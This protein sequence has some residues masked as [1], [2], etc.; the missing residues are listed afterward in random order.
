MDFKQ[1]AMRELAL[2]AGVG[3]GI[4][5]GRL[6][7]WRTVCAVEQSRYRQAVL[8]A[9]QNDGS[10]APFPIW[11]DVCTFDGRPWRGLVDVVSGGFPCTDISVA[12]KG[13]GIDGAKSGLWSE[14]ARIVGEVRPAF[15]FIENSPRLVTL[16][17]DRVL[18]DLAS[19]GYDAT[20]GVL[21]ASAVGA[22]HERKRIWILASNVD[23]TRELQSQ[24]A[25][26]EQWRRA[27]N[28]AAPTTHANQERR[29]SRWRAK[30]ALALRRCE[31][32]G[33]YQG[34]PW[35]AEPSL[36]RMVHGVPHGLE[37]VESLGDAQ[38]PRCA[39]VAFEALLAR[40]MLTSS[41]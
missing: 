34:E 26:P 27:R 8:V 41:P 6:L 35:S 25:E 39:A 36:V 29:A 15:A 22:P 7:G 11:D 18:Q 21:S 28:D 5:A 30:E 14:M 33:S 40:I 1:S 37:R 2:F 19:L 20:W 12:G 4:L 13:T 17:L 16:G 9:R 31:P 3:G 24:G 32:V 23:A 10:L 38:V